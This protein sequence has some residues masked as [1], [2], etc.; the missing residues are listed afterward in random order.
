MWL[1]IC[2]R[3]T[4]TLKRQQRKS[5]WPRFFRKPGADSEAL[6]YFSTIRKDIQK[7]TYF[8]SVRNNTNKYYDKLGWKNVI[9]RLYIE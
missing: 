7:R 1:S 9:S 4:S 5:F 2:S 3:I 8:N 6:Q